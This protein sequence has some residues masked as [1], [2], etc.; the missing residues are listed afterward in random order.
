MTLWEHPIKVSHHSANIGG[1]R[2]CDS[3]D[4]MVLVCHVISQGYSTK[5]SF[6][7]IDKS[8]SR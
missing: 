1:D 7:F 4:I 8:A 6:D 3:E 5:A 2:H